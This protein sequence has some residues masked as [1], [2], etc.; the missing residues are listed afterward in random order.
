MPTG[1]LLKVV[2]PLLLLALGAV[3]GTTVA[4]TAFADDGPTAAAHPGYR[5]A[6]NGPLADASENT[7]LSSGVLMRYWAQ[8]PSRAPAGL[9]STFANLHPSGTSSSPT[10]P[11]RATP[12]GAPQLAT[13]AVS[14]N[15]RFNNETVGFPQDEESVAKCSTGILGGANDLNDAAFAGTGDS[16]GWYYSNDSGSTLL[17]SGD[18]PGI[19]INGTFAPTGGDPASA[20]FDAGS[21]CQFYASSLDLTFDGSGNVSNSGVTLYSTTKATLDG[22]CTGNACWTSQ[23]IISTTGGSSVYDKDWVAVGSDG[24]GG[25]RIVVSWTTFDAN[26]TYV[27]AVICDQTTLG[28]SISCGSPTTLQTVAVS[29]GNYVQYSYPS[30]G[31]TGKVYV[32]WVFWKFGVATTAGGEALIKGDV[33][34]GTSWGS[35]ISI[36]TELAPNY[37]GSCLFVD[38]GCIRGGT[39]A[40]SGVG[41]N[42]RW[43]VVWDRCHDAPD[44]L[45]EC[46]NSDVRAR[47][48]DNDGATWSSPILFISGARGHQFF[49]TQPS[50]AAGGADLVVA[51]YSTQYARNQD[52]ADSRYD[53]V[54]AY[55]T[56]AD[57]AA[58]TFTTLRLTAKPSNPFSDYYQISWQF[59]GDYIGAVTDAGT[60]WVHYNAEYTML[61]MP[62]DL[63]PGSTF[64]EHQQDNYLSSF[65]YP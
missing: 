58:P 49:P 59:I 60:A 29:S 15:N 55:S 7:H 3:A 10:L 56:N 40:K 45:G 8:F 19:N 63:F 25:T 23:T 48:S 24:S 65:T 35:N 9:Q 21:G 32:S 47:F 11:T 6:Y 36:A 51:Y 13:P 42:G 46:D 34:N 38:L 28:G 43:W 16:T 31:P 33:F 27:Q 12:G 26:N 1:R 41:A 64:P 62:S 44:A 50:L 22:G 5:V 20:A 37:Q 17:K 2:V 30:V 18:L 54:A 4:L 39:Q 61:T 52:G 57:Q 53:V 14:F